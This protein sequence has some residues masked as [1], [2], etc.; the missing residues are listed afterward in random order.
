MN[1]VSCLHYMLDIFLSWKQERSFNYLAET[2]TGYTALSLNVPPHISSSYTHVNNRMNAFCEQEKKK[3]IMYTVFRKNTHSHFIS[4]IHEL[5]VDLN[6]NCSE[7]TQGLI[8]SENVEIRHS[9]R[10]MT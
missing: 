7:Y 5:F 6:K 10:S 8:D 9:L 1:L 2:K 4:Y 3:P